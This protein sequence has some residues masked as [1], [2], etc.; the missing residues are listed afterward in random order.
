MSRLAV[1]VLMALSFGIG[2]TSQ[3]WLARTLDAQGVVT[4]LKRADLGDWCP[5]KEVTVS[6]ETIGPQRQSRHYHH[7]YSFAW[8]IEGAQRRM[9]EGRPAESFA[10]GDVVE[11]APLEVSESEILTPTRVLLFRIAEKGRPLTVRVP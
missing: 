7:A 9:V 2:L 5:G 11:E 1:P 10:A 6:I 4:E 3:A 8:M